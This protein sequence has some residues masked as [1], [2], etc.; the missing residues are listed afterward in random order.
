MA[1]LLENNWLS[2]TV[3]DPTQ[4]H[5]AFHYESDLEWMPVSERPEANP[6]VPTAPT[7]VQ[8]ALTGEYE[9]AP[10]VTADNTLTL[11]KKETGLG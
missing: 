9:H 5:R 1:E 2:L 10:I 4:D 7:V 3:V 8:V 6:E 11:L